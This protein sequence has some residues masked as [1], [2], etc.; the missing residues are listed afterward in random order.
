MRRLVLL[1]AVASSALIQG[2]C[3]TTAGGNEAGGV[4]TGNGMTMATQKKF[5]VAEA[6]CA[7]YGKIAR[8]KKISVWDGTLNYECVEKG[9]AKGDGQ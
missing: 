5:A 2:G 9:S 3:A 8:V 7:K 6:E 1:L 4:V